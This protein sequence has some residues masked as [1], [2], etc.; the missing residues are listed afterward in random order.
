MSTSK[1]PNMGANEDKWF[2]YADGPDPEGHIRLHM[3]RSWTGKKDDRVDCRGGS[4]FAHASYP[5][6]QQPLPESSGNQIQ[7][8]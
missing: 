5:T 6:V 1:T 4:H 3:H 2:V 7:A 8:S